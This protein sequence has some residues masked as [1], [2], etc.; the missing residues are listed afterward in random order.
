MLL[1][2]LNQ[3]TIKWE[4]FT[5]RKHH[6]SLFHLSVWKTPWIQISLCIRIWFWIQYHS[7]KSK[8]FLFLF[9]QC[10]RM[11]IQTAIW[12]VSEGLPTPSRSFYW[13]FRKLCQ[14]VFQHRPD[15]YN[16][17]LISGNGVGR[18]SDTI[19]TASLMHK[20]IRI[21]AVSGS[22]MLIPTCSGKQVPALVLHQ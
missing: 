19:Q 10:W 11:T 17:F 4:N 21:R 13:D 8:I 22:T 2:T 15:H 18:P 5:K 20:L 16:F 14:N 9:G 12:M 7:P 1:V 3:Q 6:S